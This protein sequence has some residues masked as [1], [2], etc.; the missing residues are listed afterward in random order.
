MNRYLTMKVIDFLAEMPVEDKNLSTRLRIRIRDI[1]W[2]LMTV[3]EMLQ[4][5]PKILYQL[6]GFGRK[7]MELLVGHLASAGLLKCE[8]KDEG[9]WHEQLFKAVSRRTHRLFKGQQA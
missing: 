9:P 6:P 5:D 8:P 2:D 3:E 1:N 4:R 7:T